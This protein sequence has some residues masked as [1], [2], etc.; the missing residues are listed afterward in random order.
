MPMR[1]VNGLI[2]FL[3]ELTVAA[4]VNTSVQATQIS[5]SNASGGN[6]ST[7]SNWTGGVVP[8]AIDTALI[9]LDGTYTVTLDTD[10]TVAG[11]TLGGSI[12]RQTFSMSYRTLTINGPFTINM[13]AKTSAVYS[14]ING[15]GNIT[16]SDSLAL[17]SSTIDVP[18][19]NSGVI[20]AAHTNNYFNRAYTN[21]TASILRLWY[22]SSFSAILTV[23]SGFT[24]N[25]LLDLVSTDSG[26]YV[27][28]NAPHGTLVNS[29]TGTIAVT[30]TA[31]WAYIG[32]ELDNQGTM[33]LGYYLNLDAASAN[34]T[35]SGTIN[36][37]GGNLAINGTSFT[38]TG[39]I[40]VAS[41]YSLDVNSGTFD[42]PS[43]SITGD[44]ILDFDGATVS[45][46]SPAA[47]T[48]TLI[49]TSSTMTLPAVVWTG[50]ISLTS[51]TLTISD[52]LIIQ[53]S[54]PVTYSTINGTGNILI[55]D[56]LALMGSTIDVPIHNSGVITAVT[57]NYFNGAFTNDPGSTLKLWYPSNWGSAL[58]ID[59]SFTNN[60]LLVLFSSY[61]SSSVSVN[62]SGPLVNS[63]T[64]TIDANSPTGGQSIC[65][66]L[67]NQG[68]MNIGWPLALDFA[69]ANHSNSGTINL[70][71]GNLAIDQS[72]T[73]PSFTNTGTITVDSGRTLDV[74]GGAFDNQ[75]T[76]TLAGN[77]T[78]DLTG[79][80]TRFTNAGI[81]SPGASPG[82]L[83][84]T[85]MDMAQQSTSLINVEI[86][87]ATSG[88]FDSLAVA[89]NVT[90]GGIIN[91][92]LYN[93]YFPTIGDSITFLSASAVSGD[94]DSLDLQIG[95]IIFD[96]VSSAASVSL[97]CTQANNLDPTISL[98]A[99]Q[100]YEASD[101]V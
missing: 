14:T 32:T 79:S 65:A 18:L 48:G 62:S 53:N 35:N 49:L 73:T 86:A 19:H 76:G 93:G 61:G 26:A 6:W 90:K 55:S 94:F 81:I 60:G 63:P 25:G 67:D 56:S 72:G 42:F 39:T 75:S 23:D 45:W 43:G 77:G 1:T 41:P 84:I 7:G 31:G 27:R 10:I 13:N 34:H 16:V 33:N 80:V 8:G 40:A 3:L 24:N 15:T 96:T 57:I 85:G 64:G 50:P 12:G 30:G 99:T 4:G 66:E 98:T 88:N 44:G 11:I 70:I 91:V 58:N 2:V 46:V 38:N 78:I 92:D 83:T 9:T 69:S 100:N 101:S 68:T 54:T 5:W 22:T 36:V 47:W 20:T 51:S 37:T 97:V 52:S 89:G 87:A 82:A 17:I 29:P 71:G 74:N 21:D 95:G 59:S 28:V